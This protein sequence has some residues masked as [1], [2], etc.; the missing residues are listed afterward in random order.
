MIDFSK[1]GS[2]NE[3]KALGRSNLNL[4]RREERRLASSKRSTAI[5]ELKGKQQELPLIKAWNAVWALGGAEVVPSKETVEEP[6][7]I[8]TE[9]E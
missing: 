4:M 9:T 3:L 5:V 2:L 7:T 8:K 1:A 6:G